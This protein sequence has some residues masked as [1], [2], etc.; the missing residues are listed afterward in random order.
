MKIQPSKARFFSIFLPII[1][2]A[3]QASVF[4]SEK[5]NILFILADDMGFSDL[6][7]YGSEIQTPNIDNLARQGLRFTQFYNHA[8][9]TP[10]RNAIHTGA[11]NQQIKGAGLGSN[12]PNLMESAGYRTIYI[13]KHDGSGAPSYDMQYAI[14]G[15]S[16]YFNPGYQRAGE[17]EIPAVR[18]KDG[19]P[20]ANWVI[21]NESINVIGGE[22]EFPPDHYNTVAFTDKA[23]EY[24][25]TEVAENQPFFLYMAYT[26]PHW[27]LHALPEDKALYEGVYD[28]GWEAIRTQRFARQKKLGLFPPDTRLSPQNP[29]N[30]RWS[31]L[32]EEQKADYADRMQTHAAMIHR[33]DHGVGR[34]LRKIEEMGRL[35]NTIVV[36]LSDNG[37]SGVDLKITTQPGVY[38]TT[39]QT[40]YLAIGDEWSIAANSP[41][42]LNKTTTF[43]GGAHTPCIIR[44]PG[45]L[46]EERHGEFND[47]LAHVMDFLPTFAEAAGLP[48]P[49]D[50]EGKS[51]KP[52]VETGSRTGEAAHDWLAYQYHDYIGTRQ[53][54]WKLISE[55][56]RNW[57]LFNLGTDPTESHDLSA[58]AGQAS[59]I[60]QLETIF[61][62][63]ATRGGLGERKFFIGSYDG[64]PDQGSAPVPGSGGALEVSHISSSQFRVAHARAADSETDQSSLK[65]LRFWSYRDDL[66]T[67]DDLLAWAHP[68]GDWRTDEVSH[69]ISKSHGYAGG[70]HVHAYIMVRDEDENRAV[71]GPGSAFI[72]FEGSAPLPG[73]ITDISAEEPSSITVSWT[74]GSDSEGQSLEYSLFTFQHG[75]LQTVED[76]LT[77]GQ[78]V[79]DFQEDLQSATIRNLPAGTHYFA[80]LVRDSDHNI[81]MTPLSA[82]VAGPSADLSLGAYSTY[83]DYI[84]RRGHPPALANPLEDANFN[85]QPN[86][87]D[88][89]LGGD[90][91]ARGLK[92]SMW[93]SSQPCTLRFGGHRDFQDVRY[94][95]IAQAVPGENPVPNSA[96]FD[97]ALDPWK[98]SNEKLNM[99]VYSDESV[100]NMR[101][102]YLEL[103]LR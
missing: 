69:I 71:Y 86:F 22:Y 26:A 30:R 76:A 7:C 42:R 101:F 99:A 16:N 73:E 87:V 75:P 66:K 59:R 55:N 54:D 45:L 85:G 4:A 96:V 23:I 70:A 50:I 28:V 24:L 98:Y 47:T 79:A 97:S 1:L 52:V 91:L 74:L 40:S 88:Y 21:D 33:L 13:G 102:Y 10:T 41:Y 25:E 103:T 67:V 61:D 78:V 14:Y 93:I 89:A 36:F 35:D 20:V 18:K 9:C 46:N 48:V 83:A 43:E 39:S 95:I 92:P 81:I 3:V 32:S 68:I 27:P 94:K 11:Y 53:G 44:W 65:Y 37:A 56:G 77:Y 38:D 80:V 82:D 19:V 34:I 2:A 8:K 5:P 31:E 90:P 17:A 49:G 15:G 72:P 29:E 57:A 12:L 6:G 58:D 62:T 84:A 100:H 60:A 51:L 63:W 64:G